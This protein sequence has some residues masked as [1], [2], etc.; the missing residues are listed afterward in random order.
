MIL[1]EC[2]VQETDQIACVFEFSN[3]L[4]N[5]SPFEQDL[6]EIKAALV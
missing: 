1:G 2:S 6:M 4:R 5:L 3:D